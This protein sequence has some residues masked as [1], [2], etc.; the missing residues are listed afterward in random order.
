VF[1]VKSGIIRKEFKVINNG[2]KPVE[3]KWKI[4]PADLKSDKDVFK[5]SIT[6]PSPGS[7]DVVKVNWEAIEPEE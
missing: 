3:I 7:A 4:F 1:P 5:L 6:D 2:P